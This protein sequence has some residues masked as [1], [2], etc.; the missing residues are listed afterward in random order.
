MLERMHQDEVSHVCRSDAM[1]LQFV[2]RL[3]EKVGMENQHHISAKLGELG[4]LMAELRRTA[5][6]ASSPTSRPRSLR[7]LRRPCARLRGTMQEPTNAE[8][9]LSP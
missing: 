4:R 2:A 6:D 3:F 9:V 7:Q 5:P 8:L 1:I